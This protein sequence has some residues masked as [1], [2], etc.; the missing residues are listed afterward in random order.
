MRLIDADELL[1]NTDGLEHV[2]YSQE[3]G[4]IVLVCDIVYATTVDAVE[5]VRCRDCKNLS[6]DRI[7][8][9]WNRICRKYGCGKSDDGYC[10]EFKRKETEDE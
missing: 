2:K 7:A 4:H 9:E 5:V 3:Y 1:N 8:P 6:E 10:D